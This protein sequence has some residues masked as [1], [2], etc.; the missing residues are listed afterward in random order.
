M[1][2]WIKENYFALISFIIALVVFITCL[3]SVNYMLTQLTIIDVQ[4]VGYREYNKGI[5]QFDNSSDKKVLVSYEW[6]DEQH[7]DYILISTKKV[8]SSYRIPIEP[9]GNIYSWNR[10]M[11]NCIFVV[12]S[13][14]TMIISGALLVPLKH[15]EIQQ[16]IK[17]I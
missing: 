14:V 7:E 16:A 5:P 17:N 9:N 4:T 6:E 8:E 11:M 2:T 15:S 1:K 3:V 13:L 10:I 12:M